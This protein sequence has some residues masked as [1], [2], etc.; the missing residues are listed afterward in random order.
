MD[1]H[2]RLLA[3]FLAGDLLP[4]AAWQWDEHLLK[5]ESCRR[6]AELLRQPAPPG[7]TDRVAFAV[8]VAAAGR[9][10]NAAGTPSNR[11]GAVSFRRL[12]VAAQRSA[13]LLP[14]PGGIS[15]AQIRQ[16][17]WVARSVGRGQSAPLLPDDVTALASILAVRTFSPGS[18]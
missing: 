5:C 7:L 12:P 11:V 14:M 8:E 4:A 1:G 2:D 3:A 16:A 18:V 13:A 17:A 15:E 6:A 10:R 9:G